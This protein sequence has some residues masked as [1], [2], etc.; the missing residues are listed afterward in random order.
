MKVNKYFNL[1]Q[2]SGISAL[3]SSNS[4]VTG[5]CG[6]HGAYVVNL[7]SI[8]EALR[9]FQDQFLILIALYGSKF[10]KNG[11]FLDSKCLNHFLETK[12]KIV[13][14]AGQPLE[15]CGKSKILFTFAGVF[16][17][18]LYEHWIIQ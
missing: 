15:Y 4:D 14:Y 11:S 8:C 1:P 3:V 18:S 16:N 13:G 12:L 5:L 17:L 6:A 7:K 2:D 10:I 9:V